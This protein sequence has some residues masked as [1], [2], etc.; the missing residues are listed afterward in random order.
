MEE[1]KEEFKVCKGPLPENA[2]ET[3]R[4]VDKEGKPIIEEGKPKVH[5]RHDFELDDRYQWEGYKK[6][7]KLRHLIGV[8][9]DLEDG[10]HVSRFLVLDYPDRARLFRTVVVGANGDT[11]VTNYDT[12]GHIKLEQHLSD[13]GLT[14]T[15]YH[16]RYKDGKIDPKRR[17][18]LSETGP[19]GFKAPQMTVRECTVDLPQEFGELVDDFETLKPKREEKTPEPPEDQSKP[20]FEGTPPN[21]Y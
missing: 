18:G 11:H 1:K 2:F 15:F 5:I 12:A 14:E 8:R 20:D 9:H 21:R 17:V 4:F 6:Y 19:E 10:G 13:A 16:Y 7:D 3:V